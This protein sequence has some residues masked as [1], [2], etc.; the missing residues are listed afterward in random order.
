MEEEP[1]PRN[2]IIGQ[3][4]EEAKVIRARQM[5]REMTLTEAM[6]WLRLRRNG[7][8]VHFRPQVVLD[9]FI[10]DFYCHAAALVVEVDGPLHDS[11]YDAERDLVFARRGIKVLR[12]QN[13]EILEK[14][15][16]VLSRIRQRL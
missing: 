14:I 6:L 5:R 16:F 8:G 13:E 1:K 9:G 11:A 2:V 3:H 7:L 10:V 12:F 15:G 4:V